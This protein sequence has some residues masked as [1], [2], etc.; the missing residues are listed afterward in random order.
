MANSDSHKDITKELLYN[1]L[2]VTSDIGF[3]EYL[4]AGKT[5]KLPSEATYKYQVS[6]IENPAG[7]TTAKGSLS[8]KLYYCLYGC[9]KNSEA[10]YLAKHGWENGVPFVMQLI[11]LDG[12]FGARSRCTVVNEVAFKPDDPTIKSIH[13]FDHRHPD[14]YPTF[15]ISATGCTKSAVKKTLYAVGDNENDHGSDKA[16]LVVGYWQSIHT[17]SKEEI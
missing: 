17:D 11:N 7:I 12:F 4:K 5:V 16:L 15:I 9:A 3:L 6:C 1:Q 14:S 13:R 2:G 10:D 8:Q